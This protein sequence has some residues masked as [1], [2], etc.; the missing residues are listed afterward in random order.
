MKINRI[1]KLRN[2]IT[3]LVIMFFNS[4]IAMATSLESSR[5]VTG[6]QK[7]L[8]DASKVLLILA[9]VSGACFIGY[10]L[11]R[12]HGADETDDKKWKSRIKITVI[13]TVGVV[14]A[15]GTLNVIISYYK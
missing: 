7:L 15:S 5:L 6:T 10:F 2:M 3:L 9:P 11:T 8:Q 14:L 13:A 12:M 1:K 4:N